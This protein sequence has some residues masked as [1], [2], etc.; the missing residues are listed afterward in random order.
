MI[1]H[2]SK[3]EAKGFT[4]E[5][6]KQTIEYLKKR[7]LFKEDAFIKSFIRKKILKGT[8]T[9]QIKLELEKRSVFVTQ[10][11]I[12][13]EIQSLEINPIE[14]LKKHLRKKIPSQEHH[15]NEPSKIK[16]KLIRYASQRGYEY[17]ESLEIIET[18][19]IEHEF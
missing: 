6:I 4:S 10:E 3:I 9:D 2:G 18:L 14:Q 13:R 12:L 11:E 7:N 1:I 19:L 8:S 5:E 16:Q 17:E 15:K